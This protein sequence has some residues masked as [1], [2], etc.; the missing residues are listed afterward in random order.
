MLGPKRL[1]DFSF[2]SCRALNMA[3]IYTISFL[4]LVSIG[5][6]VVDAKSTINDSL[7]VTSSKTCFSSND[8]PPNHFCF[9]IYSPLGYTFE[10]SVNQCMPLV[11]PG[12]RCPTHEISVAPWEYKGPTPCT[13][14]HSCHREQD[15][16]TRCV[17]DLVRG[18]ICEDRYDALLCPSGNTCDEDTT[19]QRRCRAC[20]GAPCPGPGGNCTLN[21]NTFRCRRS[22]CIQNRPNNVICRGDDSTWLS[23]SC[24]R[25][26]CRAFQGIG[27]LCLSS[28]YCAGHDAPD[29]NGD[30][31]ICNHFQSRDGMGRCYKDSQLL[32]KLGAPCLRKK[33][34]CDRRRHLS[35]LWQRSQRRFVC[36]QRGFYRFCTPNHPLSRC[37][38]NDTSCLM[39]RDVERLTGGVE[40]APR[41]Y[42]CLM[43]PEVVPL[44]TPCNRA[45]ADVICPLGASCEP[46][47]YFP[48]PTK[49]S[50]FNAK[51]L[52]C[53]FLRGVG[54]SCENI[55]ETKCMGGLQCDS[56]KCVQRKTPAIT[57]QR[58]TVYEER[59]DRCEKNPDLPCM[60]GMSCISGECQQP[61]QIVGEGQLCHTSPLFTKVRDKT[62][63][64]S[65]ISSGV[66]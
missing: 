40:D 12:S 20:L 55:F 56:G 52:V 47:R 32:K 33:D 59:Y 36:Q 16:T 41:F 30:R 64:H 4:V 14:G 15:F 19:G 29:E 26:Q 11:Q 1:A 53:L 65:S 28:R 31:V 57:P 24:V 61:I 58:D 8:C 48:G 35:C 49:D 18:S 34:R 63:P 7:L 9:T 60:P 54:E 66:T 13:S 45:L 37:G 46:W 10:F 50:R 2:V 43:N 6:I 17:P 38:S 22:V 23:Q 25:G 5:S 51:L 44:G 21:Q 62:L 42:R 39:A 27:N 3:F